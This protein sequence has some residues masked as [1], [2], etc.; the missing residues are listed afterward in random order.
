MKPLY[1]S[2]TMQNGGKT[3]LILG[4]LEAFRDAGLNVGYMKPVGQ[5]Y[6]EYEGLNID[7]DAVLAL[8]AFDLKDRA[9]DMSPVAIE[10]GFTEQYIFNRDP[11]PLEERIL[12]AFGRLRAAHECLVVEGTGHAGVGSCFDLSNARVAELLGAAV[13]IV[14]DGGIGRA[15]DE[16]A[17]SLGAFRR[18]GVQVLGVILNKV[19]HEK[20]ARVQRAVAEGLRHL[21]TELL[22]AIPYRTTLVQ[23]CIEQIV[24]E[25]RGRLL[26]GHHALGNRVEHTVIAAMA[27][28]HVCTYVREN[29]LIVTPGDRI[30]NIVVSIVA[31]PEETDGTRSVAGLVLTGGFKPPL[32]IMTLLEASG[33]PVVLCNED[34]Y[35]VATQLRE[36]TFKIRPEDGDKIA[37][38][39]ELIRASLDVPSLLAALREEG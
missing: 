28:Q 9:A 22:A 30:D 33:I 35:S 5:R 26:C 34:T 8:R 13:V 4:L 29:T 39:K 21:G 23:P 1:V 10:R 31:C 7:E 17:L 15:I 3:T 6:V 36:L 24:A 27:P 37:E 19:W 20:Q 16:V 18:Q 11:K 2:A 25:V 12:A 38:A 14:T 32:S